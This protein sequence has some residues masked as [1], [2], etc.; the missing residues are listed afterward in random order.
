MQT[1]LENLLN[2][3]LPEA[4]QERKSMLLSLFN[5]ILG[6]NFPDEFPNLQVTFM[7]MSNSTSQSPKMLE[8]VQRFQQKSF[9]FNKEAV[10]KCLLK[11]AQENSQ[12]MQNSTLTMRQS[13]YSNPT[14]ASFTFPLVQL[15]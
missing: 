12:K 3:S 2:H 13:F 14:E 5:R 8:L 1:L 9:I 11:V 4:K 15:E 6:H 10:L 7:Q